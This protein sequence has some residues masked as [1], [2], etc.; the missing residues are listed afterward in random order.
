V[1]GGA[2]GTQDGVGSQQFVVM[3][4]AP[5]GQSAVLVHAI[6]RHVGRTQV[7]V[8]SVVATQG[9]PPGQ[10]P[11]VSHEGSEQMLGG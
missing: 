6:P 5:G 11:G 8:P 4:T 2:I 10:V 7:F 9:Q 1:P 3:Q